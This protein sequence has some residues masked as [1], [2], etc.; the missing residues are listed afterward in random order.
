MRKMILKLWRDDAGIVALEYL[1][2]ATIVGLGLVVGLSNLEI[3][4]DNELT[5]LAN[6]VTAL[7]QSY[8]FMSVY[9]RGFRFGMPTSYK[10]GTNAYDIYGTQTATVMWPTVRAPIAVLVP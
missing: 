8:S 3:A 2:L 6:A 9:G 7:D 4:L 5:E 10:A 1:L